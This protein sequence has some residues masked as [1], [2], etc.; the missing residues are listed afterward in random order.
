MALDSI[1]FSYFIWQRAQDIYTSSKGYSLFGTN[2]IATYD[3]IN[4]G[5]LHNS[6]FLAS[7]EGMENKDYKLIQQLFLN[8]EL[9]EQRIYGIKFFRLAVPTIVVVDDYIPFYNT[10]EAAFAKPTTDKGLWPIILEKAFAKF[11]GS[12]YST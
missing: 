1:D 5:F 7:L 9:N 6:W 4:Q 8:P 12:Y 3:T 11:N 10:D 2:N